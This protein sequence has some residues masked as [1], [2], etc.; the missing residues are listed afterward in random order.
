MANSDEALSTNMGNKQLTS[1]LF[2]KDK[3]N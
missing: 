1:D 2:T 3:N